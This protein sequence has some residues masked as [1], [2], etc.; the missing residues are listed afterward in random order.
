MKT[1]RN[2]RL[3][4]QSDSTNSS[5]LQCISFAIIYRTKKSRKPTHFCLKNLS[6]AEAWHPCVTVGTCCSG[7][8]AV[9]VCSHSLVLPQHQ[10]GPPLMSGDLAWCSSSS[11][12]CSMRLRS[13]FS[14]RAGQ[15]FPLLYGTGFVYC[16]VEMGKGQTQTVNTKLEEHNYPKIYA[17]LSPGWFTSHSLSPFSPH[18][19]LPPT[20]PSLLQDNQ[21]MWGMCESGCVSSLR[22]AVQ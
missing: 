19:P 15:V 2:P 5:K 3:C 6:L 16:H 1:S 10:W 8:M 17:T 12:R 9:G 4:L 14:V 7:P 18:W 22:A 11:Q 21:I 20:P 13:G